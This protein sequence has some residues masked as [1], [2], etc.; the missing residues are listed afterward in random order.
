MTEQRMLEPLYIPNQSLN[1]VIMD[2]ETELAIRRAR[3]K[4]SHGINY[5][6][7]SILK[8][9]TLWGVFK[10][11]FQLCMDTSKIPNNWYR[12]IIKPLPKS[13]ENGP[14]VTLNDRGISLISCTLKLF[15]GIMN[16]RVTIFF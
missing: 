7:N 1:N 5:L 3:Y 9:E 2:G 4:K 6:L 13:S 15:T 16:R 14:Q 8:L 10:E 11:L 12:G